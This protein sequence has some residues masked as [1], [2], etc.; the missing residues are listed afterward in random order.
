MTEDNKKIECTFCNKNRK[1]VDTMI[2]GPVIDEL[3]L[4]ICNGCVSELHELIKFNSKPKAKQNKLMPPSE[5]RKHLDQFIIGQESAKKAISI[6][7]YNHY[8]R[9][10]DIGVSE[11]KL[12]KSNVMVIGPSGTGKTLIASTVADI[13]NLPFAIGDATTLTEAGYIGNDVENLIK[14]L[15]QSA[16]GNISKAEH[17]VV[18]IDEIDKKRRRSENSN[19]KDVSGEGVQQ[20]LLKLVEGTIVKI[21]Y[22]QSEIEVNTENILFIC[23]GAFVGLSE[24]VKKNRQGK[25]T[26]G[27]GADITDTDVDC[28]LYLGA[29]SD[30]LISYGM[31]PEFVGRFPVLVTLEHLT[32]TDMESILKEPKNSIVEQYTRLFE[33]DGV[34]L[35]FA[36]KYIKS[37][38]QKGFNQRTGARGLRSIIE[39]DLSSIQYELPDLATQGYKYVYVQDD[40]TVK[41]TKRKMIS[42]TAKKKTDA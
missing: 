9:V 36:D 5:I 16:D 19:T 17:G 29:S 42:K 28:D 34:G 14:R 30:D 12:Q 2:E 21:E 25:S 6:A 18:F 10:N 8:K 23:G 15:V 31:I 4:Y 39:Q 26:I 3:E 11:T 24:I 37:V 1:Q 38:A 32:E 13:M 22:E 40:G 33:I 27:F 41:P 7:I 20:A 35:S